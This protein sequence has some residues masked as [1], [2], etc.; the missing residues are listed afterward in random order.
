M[1]ST[2]PERVVV[3]VCCRTWA[4]LGRE[5]AKIIKQHALR[6]VFTRIVPSSHPTFTGF[7]F[8]AKGGSTLRAS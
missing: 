2:V 8:V 1:L 3:C 6:I 5:E 4:Q 7:R